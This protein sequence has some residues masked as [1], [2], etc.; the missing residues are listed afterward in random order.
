VY[1]V[2]SNSTIDSIL[3]QVLGAVQARIRA[4]SLTGVASGSVLYKKLELSRMFRQPDGLTLPGVLITP[5]RQ[6]MNPRAGTTSQD[7]V[8]YGVLVTILRADNQ[9]ATIGV[10]LDAQTLA[11]E[12]IAKAFRN[13]RLSGVTEITTC[14]VE[15]SDTVLG[16]AWQKNLL[17]SSMVLR[18]TSREGR[19]I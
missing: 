9:E 16:P 15:G 2:V 19:G 12:K 18:F 14:A 6:T 3:Y 11:Y 13:Q 7:D 8:E 4:V 10:D 5:G 17:A 1:F